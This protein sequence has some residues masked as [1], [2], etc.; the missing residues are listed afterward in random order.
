MILEITGQLGTPTYSAIV[1]HETLDFSM[2]VDQD[3][4]GQEY[5]FIFTF[6]Q[7]HFDGKGVHPP[8][9][10]GSICQEVEFRRQTSQSR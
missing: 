2:A 8:P 10:A 3:S 6:L 5:F 9:T 7:C 4:G 1:F